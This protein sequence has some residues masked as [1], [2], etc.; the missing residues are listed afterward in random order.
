MTRYAHLAV[1]PSI[2]DRDPVA[3]GIQVVTGDQVGVVGST[4]TEN[5]AHL[6]YEQRS[7][8]VGQQV[9]FDGVVIPVGT[10]YGSSDPLVTST[11][12]PTPPGAPPR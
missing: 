11:N 2:V 12:C 4:G 1:V 7:S 5:Q 9:A 3:P 8:G 10:T 6:H